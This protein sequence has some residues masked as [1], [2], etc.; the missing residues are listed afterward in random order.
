MYLYQCSVQACSLRCYVYDNDDQSR[1]SPKCMHFGLG[2]GLGLDSCGLGFGLG[3]ATA[4]LDY[5][6]GSVFHKYFT[7]IQIISSEPSAR[8]EYG[9][10]FHTSYS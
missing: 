9:T 10:T 3:L 2:L 1:C 6:L 5:I 8:M 7:Y 4:G